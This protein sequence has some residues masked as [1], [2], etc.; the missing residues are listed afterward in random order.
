[1]N[2]NWR[3]GNC[4]WKVHRSLH[5]YLIHVSVFIDIGDSKRWHSHK[6]HCQ[7]LDSEN[8]PKTLGRKFPFPLLVSLLCNILPGR[9]SNGV[10]EQ[11]PDNSVDQNQMRPDNTEVQSDC[12][13]DQVWQLVRSPGIM[14]RLRS[15][16]CQLVALL[17]LN[18]L[19]GRGT[20]FLTHRSDRCC[21]VNGRWLSC[22]GSESGMITLDEWLVKY[23]S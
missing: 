19:T 21:E 9:K 20:F 17:L 2:Y 6:T 10:E 13:S 11:C 23:V 16:Q 18:H 3:W 22:S 12:H 15:P 8:A 5:S 4:P 7:A 14:H 1:M